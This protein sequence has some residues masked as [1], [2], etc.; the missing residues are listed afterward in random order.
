[1]L[2][3]ASAESQLGALKYSRDPWMTHDPSAPLPLRDEQFPATASPA[4]SSDK[5]SLTWL[6]RRM[7]DLLMRAPSA[8]GITA[9]PLHRWV[10]V[11]MAPRPHGGRGTAGRFVRR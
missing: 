4:L 10:Y 3:R 2:P 5:N 8:I 7:R 11:N 6:N 1:M 9:G